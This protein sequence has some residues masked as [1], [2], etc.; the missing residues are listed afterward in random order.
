MI[1]G[2]GQDIV[3]MR[4]I[5]KI[6][7]RH[8]ERFTRRYFTDIEYNKAESRRTAK[9]HID[10]Y[11]K[12]FA[13]KEAVAKALGCGFRDG[14]HICDIGVDNDVNG[15]PVITLSDIAQKH[16]D[17]MTPKGMKAVIHITLSDEPPI[18]QALAIIEARA[19]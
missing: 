17:Q 12:R 10:T 11:A 9:R 4:R 16:L 18:A 3:D 8:N 13:A 7:E 14:L 6:I 19:L 1:I 15:A 5:K 2:I